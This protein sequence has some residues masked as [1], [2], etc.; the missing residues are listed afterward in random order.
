MTDAFLF[1]L[2]KTLLGKAT[3]Q[4]LNMSSEDR[5]RRKILTQCKISMPF[6]KLKTIC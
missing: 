5:K 6:I 1:F 2:I 3:F 4:P